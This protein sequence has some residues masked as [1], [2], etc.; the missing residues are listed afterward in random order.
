MSQINPFR[1]IIVPSSKPQQVQLQKDRRQGRQPKQ[2][3]KPGQEDQQ[4]SPPDPA[5]PHLDLKA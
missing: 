5:D 2:D 4:K 1:G 3:P